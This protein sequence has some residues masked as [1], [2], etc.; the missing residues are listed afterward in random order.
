MMKKAK[1]WNVIP[2]DIWLEIFEYVKNISQILDLMT[3]C[4]T[5]HNLLTTKKEHKTKFE[6]Y[7]KKRFPLLKLLNRDKMLSINPEGI[8][9]PSNLS[10][11]MQGEKPDLKFDDAEKLISNIKISDK[12]KDQYQI[13]LYLL[14]FLRNE[15]EKTTFSIT[16]FNGKP[17]IAIINNSY[18]R[19]TEKLELKQE[20]STIELFTAIKKLQ[21]N[22]LSY[23]LKNPKLIPK[24]L[25]LLI[26]GNLQFFGDENDLDNMFVKMMKP[27]TEVK[28]MGKSAEGGVVPSCPIS[29]TVL[30]SLAKTCYKLT[31]GHLFRLNLKLTCPNLTTLK[32]NE[33]RV[34]RVEKSIKINAPQLTTVHL[35]HK[36]LLTRT[37]VVTVL[38]KKFKNI[39]TI[40]APHFS[41][42]DGALKLIIR[43]F[44]NGIAV[45]FSKITIYRHD[46]PSVALENF[47]TSICKTFVNLNKEQKLKFNQRAPIILSKNFYVPHKE[48]SLFTKK[49]KDHI[50]L[51]TEKFNYYILGEF[52]DNVQHTNGHN[53]TL[54]SNQS[55]LF[56]NNR[57]P[58]IIDQNINDNDAI[59]TDENG[60]CTNEDNVNLDGWNQYSSP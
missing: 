37:S 45:K 57:S 4:K 25:K 33:S 58:L 27:F 3:C 44:K 11:F 56:Q 42:I 38:R 39:N 32:I 48:S 36:D 52:K 54:A 24:N 26:I 30:T 28:L 59:M 46:D 14:H 10:K 60:F 9:L 19:E 22:D 55:S 23:F 53:P 21:L 1:H 47:S 41:S 18:S 2:Y 13:Y 17:H 43:C 8:K 5:F 15:V 40:V 7:V 35:L 51:L 50:Q 16:L 20:I 29:K 6:A 12:Y 31:F 49:F 34:K